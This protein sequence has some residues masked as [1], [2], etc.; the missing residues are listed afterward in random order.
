MKRGAQADGIRRTVRSS[1][2]SWQIGAAKGLKPGIFGGT[3]LRLNESL[4]NICKISDE[5]LHFS[6]S[7]KGPV[8][9]WIGPFS[10]IVS[11]L[12]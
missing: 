12:F 2:G 7:K 11:I 6:I 10:D 1:G 5:F 3:E 9:C 4:Y 8:L